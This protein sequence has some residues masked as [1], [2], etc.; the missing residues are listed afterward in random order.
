[1]FKSALENAP[2]S[3]SEEEALSLVNNT[4]TLIED[5]Y[6]PVPDF[7]ANPANEAWDGRMY[8]VHGDNVVS[9]S[10][11]SGLARLLSRGSATFIDEHG[12]HPNMESTTTGKFYV[13]TVNEL[14]NGV[15][16]PMGRQLG[17]IAQEALALFNQVLSTLHFLSERQH[18]ISTPLLVCF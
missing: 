5:V 15:T 10:R 17:P 2:Y 7:R 3:S 14:K 8:P 6:S 11:G 12:G 9:N 18:A 16:L 13:F 1:M 4:L